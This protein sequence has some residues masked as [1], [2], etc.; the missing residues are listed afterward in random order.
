VAVARG[1]GGRLLSA[2]FLA[3]LVAG[4][5]A[6]FG[7]E[8]ATAQA[9]LGA[10]SGGVF[11]T[12]VGVSGVAG[13]L[14]GAL[15]AK[16]S[17]RRLLAATASTLAASCLLLAAAPGLVLVSAV[18]YG[19]SFIAIIG[20]LLIWS[21]ALVPQAPSTGIATAMLVMA[22]GLVIG[23][24]LAGLVAGAAGLATVF[25]MCAPL[26]ATIGLLHPARRRPAT[27]RP[28]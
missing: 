5:Y 10:V 13:G 20:L 2:T 22:L 15:L 28:A 18:L 25:V 9:P 26:A 21:N 12:V 23:P 27:P 11:Q 1:Q 14:V 17:L 24:P 16:T 8:I 6:T 3:G 7:V 19:A 4:S